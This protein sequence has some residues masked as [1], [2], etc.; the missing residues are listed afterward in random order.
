MGLKEGEPTAMDAVDPDI[1]ISSTTPMP[2]VR[3]TRS[4][5]QSTSCQATSRLG[6]SAIDAARSLDGF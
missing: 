5:K 4:N 2:A 6:T 3:Q 1:Q